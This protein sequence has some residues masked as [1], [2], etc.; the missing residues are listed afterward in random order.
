[1]AFP[2]SGESFSGGEL[3]VA[4][5]HDDRSVSFDL[6]SQMLLARNPLEAISVFLEA[7]QIVTRSRG[8]PLDDLKS[9]MRHKDGYKQPAI[10]HGKLHAP[11]GLVC[12]LSD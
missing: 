12:G 2:L 1:M 11:D 8:R 9:R 7:R 4:S 5:L 3:D 6:P 10:A